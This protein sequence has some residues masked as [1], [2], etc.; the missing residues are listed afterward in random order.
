MARASLIAACAALGA[1]WAR[2]GTLPPPERLGAYAR[3]MRQTVE[4]ATVRQTV[5]PIETPLSLEVSAF[6]LDHP[7]MSAWLVRRHK[8]APYVIEMRGPGRS[9]ADDGD[10]TTGFIDLADRGPNARAYYTEGTHH[11]AVFPDIR[12][13]AVILMELAP[14]T[15]PGCREHVISS[16]DVS[17]KMRSAFV[18][19]M[20]KAL[21]P[22]IRRLIVRKFTRA[23]SVAQQVG[24]LL[25]KE[26]DA[27][28]E[29]LLSFPALTAED[30]AAADKL[31][32]SLQP[33]PAA[34]L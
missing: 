21:R 6:L 25:A 11:S 29:E 4:R 26:P 27:T 5:G 14:V 7:D 2:A 24:V 34:C 32:S 8:L 20:V 13:S 3:P 30:R 31:L 12:A 10:G 19:G 16:F 1:G 22:F 9:W 33:E 23:F 17:V 18:S 28:R 15:R